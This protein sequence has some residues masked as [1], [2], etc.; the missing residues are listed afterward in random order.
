MPHNP[1]KLL[2][3]VK[4]SCD[5]ISD[6]ILGK[7]FSDFQDDRILQLALEREFEIIGEALSR[8]AF[9]KRTN[10]LSEF[11]NTVRS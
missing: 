11:L 7:S 6:F 5:E 4:L 2:L 10:L 3:D 1:R 9:M 8:L